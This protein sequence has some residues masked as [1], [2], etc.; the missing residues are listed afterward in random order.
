M[1]TLQNAQIKMHLKYS[2]LQYM[3][4]VKQINNNNNNNKNRL[5]FCVV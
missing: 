1:S 2:V 3:N 5:T 4:I